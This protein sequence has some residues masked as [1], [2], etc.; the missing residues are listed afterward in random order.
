MQKKGLL[1]ISLLTLW[2][3]GTVISVNAECLIEIIIIK[4]TILDSKNIPINGAS[5]SAF[6][7]DEENGYSVLSSEKGEFRIEYIYDTYVGYSYDTSVGYS[8]DGVDV[9]GKEP[10]VLTIIAYSKSYYPKKVKLLE[11]LKYKATQK[12]KNIINI[13]PPPTVLNIP[14]TVLIQKWK[15]KNPKGSDLD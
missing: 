15:E 3:T 1:I 9:C 6:F 14:P 10:S 7:D 5:I 11:P 4:G 12:G 13:P 2:I 8:N